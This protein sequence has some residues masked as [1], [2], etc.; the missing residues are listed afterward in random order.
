M[1]NT[2]AV[3]WG[4]SKVETGLVSPSGAVLYSSHYVLPVNYEYDG[5]YLSE[6]VRSEIEKMRRA[7]GKLNAAAVGVSAPAVCDSER[8]IVISNGAG[9]YDW[10]LKEDFERA[11]GLPVVLDKDTNACAM[12]ERKFG[13]C[14]NTDNFIWI[15][16]SS[17]CGAGLFLNGKPFRGTNF[18]AGEVGYI[19]VEYVDPLPT[20]EDGLSGDMEDEG[21]GS[22][23]GRRYLQLSGRPADPAFRSKEVGE[24]ARA[25]DETAQSV[26][27]R[28]GVYIS[29]LA[30]MTANLLNVQKVVLG[31]GTIIYDYD[32]IKKG[33]D[34]TLPTLLRP[35][36]AKDFSVEVTALGYHASLIGAGAIAQ[37]IV[38]E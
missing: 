8:G 35:L 3:D 29:R 25:G 9:I 7:Y 19:Q 2:I 34:E 6:C 15:T 14:K 32:L 17:G 22:A 4:G 36:S 23:M 16:V 5:A 26:F 21:C 33:I 28:T 38:K 13:V 30:A 18:A 11:L 10:H 12:A 37:E 27:Y 20:V 31:G 1:K 24:L